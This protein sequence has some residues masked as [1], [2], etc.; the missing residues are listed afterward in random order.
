[1]EGSTTMKPIRLGFIGLGHITTG[2]H[3]PALAPLVETGEVNFAG[4]L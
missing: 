2:A 3:L 4:I 1:M